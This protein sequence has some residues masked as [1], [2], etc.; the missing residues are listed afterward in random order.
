D[1]L[2]AQRRGTLCLQ[3]RSQDP[4]QI[5]GF[6]VSKRRTDDGRSVH[7]EEPGADQRCDRHR[8]DDARRKARST[9]RC[10]K[11]AMRCS[12]RSPNPGAPAGVFDEE[13]LGEPR[14]HRG[15][16]GGGRVWTA[17]VGTQGERTRST[18]LV[19]SMAAFSALSL[20]PDLD[21]IAFRFGIPYSAPWGHRGAAHSIVIALALATVAVLA[22][23]L[24]P[25]QVGLGQTDK[26]LWLLCAG[27]AISHGLLDTLTDGG[28]GIALL[29][30]FSNA[31]YFAP[32]RPIP[33][34]PIGQ[35]MWSERGLRVVLTE[36][37]Q[38]APLLFWASWPRR[39]PA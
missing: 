30:P 31:R 22:T 26:L 28:L 3:S 17:L 21:V 20:A 6:R 1:A 7:P 32:F 9:L 39:R 25:R 37:L 16:H 2:R 11:S 29:W 8:R 14:S 38:F 34:A 27:V 10:W 35:G 15:R 18:T 19:R 13:A 33:V 23:R 5:T 36:A 12:P 24:Q 4:S